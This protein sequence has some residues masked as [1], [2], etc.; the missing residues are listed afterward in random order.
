MVINPSAASFC[1]V[2]TI[3]CKHEGQ[4]DKVV[5]VS[6]LFSMVRQQYIT[7]LCQCLHILCLIAV[8]GRLG[9]F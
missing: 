6:A 4:F 2:R 5:H 8:A 7:E 3:L 9:V 1:S